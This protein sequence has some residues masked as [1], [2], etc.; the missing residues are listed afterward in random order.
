MAS[1]G[2]IPCHWLFGSPKQHER[3]LK[4][5]WYLGGGVAFEEITYSRKHSLLVILL[6]VWKKKKWWRLQLK[7]FILKKKKKTFFK[8]RNVS[9]RSHSRMYLVEQCKCFTGY[10]FCDVGPLL[11][12]LRVS[13]G[14][15]SS[16]IPI[17]LCGH[18]VFHGDKTLLGALLLS[19][20]VLLDLVIC[21]FL[22][23]Q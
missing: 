18:L 17:T 1:S 7:Y 20:H 16:I 8:V 19:T 3:A 11:L 23:R 2:L 10:D 21:G 14:L 12:Q 13:Y 9:Q 6:L 4:W 22:Q 15:S 5:G